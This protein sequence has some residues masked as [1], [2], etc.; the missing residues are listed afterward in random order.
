MKVLGLFEVSAVSGGRTGLGLR[1]I[2]GTC[3][4]TSVS[5]EVMS[6]SICVPHTILVVSMLGAL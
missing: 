6:S 3:E 2:I 4:V 1:I 5:N